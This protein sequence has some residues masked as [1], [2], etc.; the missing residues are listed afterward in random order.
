MLSGK[1]LFIIPTDAHYYKIVGMFKQFKNYNI[2][3]EMLRF[4]QEPSSWSSPVL[5]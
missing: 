1:T 2:C 4:R 5:G 3:P